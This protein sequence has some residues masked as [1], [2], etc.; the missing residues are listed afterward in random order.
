MKRIII[1][2]LAIIVSV[3]SYASSKEPLWTGRYRQS[4]RG[5]CVENGQYSQSS[6]P[7]R[8][9]TV[10]MYDDHIWVEGE[11]CEYERS[12]GYGTKVYVNNGWGGMYIYYYVRVDRTMYME[13]TSNQF[14]G[15]TMRYSMESL[16]E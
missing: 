5:Y 13:T 7:S 16:E 15:I 4:G 11:Y 8:V 6:L 9:V 1:I 10:E 2:V 3:S 12:I 14:P